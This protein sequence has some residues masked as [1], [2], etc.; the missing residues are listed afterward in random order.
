METTEH[1][2]SDVPQLVWDL[3]YALNNSGWDNL[4]DYLWRVYYLCE[5]REW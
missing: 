1:Q 3:V 5:L 2:F 4:E